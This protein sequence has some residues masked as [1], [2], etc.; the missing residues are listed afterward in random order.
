MPYFDRSMASTVSGVQQSTTTSP[1]GKLIRNVPSSNC[2]KASTNA[3]VQAASVT[4]TKYKCDIDMKRLLYMRNLLRAEVEH[5]NN[6][7]SSLSTKNSKRQYELYQIDKKTLLLKG[8]RSKIFKATNSDYPTHPLM[9]RIYPNKA[10]INPENSI[11]LKFLRHLSKKHAS[12]V[13]TWEV[14]ADNAKNI[15]IFQEFCSAGNL[16]DY[17][18]KKKIDELEIALYGW[19]LLRGLD[20]LGDIGICHRDI[21]PRNLMLREANEYHMI[22]ITNFKQAIIYWSIQ[23]NDVAL[24]SCRPAKQQASDGL[25]FMAPEVY[26]DANNETKWFDQAKQIKIAI[27]VTS[28]GNHRDDTSGKDYLNKFTSK[29]FFS[30]MEYPDI[31]VDCS[32]NPSISSVDV[33]ASQSANSATMSTNAT[34]I[35]PKSSIC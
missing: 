2:S 1:Q 11:Y 17:I 22:K 23:D 14:F 25:H 6:T 12:I 32:K 7:R 29:M 21:Q 16:Q 20:F 33:S 18:N 10:K 34:S 9:C 35:A 31:G 28:A 4:A 13:H 19:Q 8:H 26:G 27:M 5:I 3:N 30:P 24:V 15:E